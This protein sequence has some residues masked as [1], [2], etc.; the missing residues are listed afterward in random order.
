[1]VIKDSPQVAATAVIYNGAATAIFS[2]KPYS[3][4]VKTVDV[5]SSVAGGVTCYKGTPGGAFTR[6]WGS[7]NG[8]SQQYTQPFKL[9]SGQGLFVVWDVAPSSVSDASA[10]ITWIEDT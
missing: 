9:P 5:S 6:V 8:A 7:S 10:R 4:V 2:S 1:M 3:R